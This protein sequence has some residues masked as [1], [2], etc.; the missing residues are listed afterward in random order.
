MGTS[1][2]N[3]TTRSQNRWLSSWTSAEI[4][5]ADLRKTPVV[6]STCATE[7]HGRYTMPI[8]TDYLLASYLTQHTIGRMKPSMRGLFLPITPFGYSPEHTH[9]PGTIT[10]RYETYLALLM[11]IGAS[12]AS[13]GVKRVLIANYHGGNPPLN[14]IAIME[15]A[16]R[17]RMIAAEY[18]YARELEFAGGLFGKEEVQYGYH[19]GAAEYALGKYFFPELL[20][21]RGKGK[22]KSAFID[23]DRSFQTLRMGSGHASVAWHAEQAHSSGAIGTSTTVTA[24]QGERYAHHIADRLIGALQDLAALR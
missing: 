3:T 24:A 12:L 2:R 15:F 14:Q 18:N 16:N 8:G 21:P 17:F 23:L 13:W 19:A 9:F 11:D 5:S 1:K 6:I 7:Q 20:Q 4:R 10:L 22:F